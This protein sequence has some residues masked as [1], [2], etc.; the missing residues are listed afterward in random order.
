MLPDQRS[1]HGPAT[2][3]VKAHLACA[4]EQMREELA[5]RRESLRPRSNSNAAPIVLP[6]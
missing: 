3:H 1:L 6:L 2:G 4:F 5:T